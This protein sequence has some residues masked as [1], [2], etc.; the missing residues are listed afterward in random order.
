M[1]SVHRTLSLCVSNNCKKRDSRLRER[2]RKREKKEQHNETKPKH[3]TQITQDDS[4]RQ[5]VCGR[6]DA[7]NKYCF[8]FPR[9]QTFQKS[10][11]Y[12]DADQTY[13]SWSIGTIPRSHFTVIVHVFCSTKHWCWKAKKK[14]ISEKNFKLQRIVS[15]LKNGAIR[16]LVS[17]ST[18]ESFEI[19]FYACWAFAIQL[20]ISISIDT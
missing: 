19:V 16:T 1:H 4:A 15:G 10:N 8:F 2:Y 18:K 5:P 17:H 13:V 12:A 11:A 9:F 6:S 20:K 14:R 7:S 3:T